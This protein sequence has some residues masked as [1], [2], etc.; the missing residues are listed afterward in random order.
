[1]MQVKDTHKSTM[2]EIRMACLSLVGAEKDMQLAPSKDR[3]LAPS[4]DRFALQTS[5][6]RFALQTTVFF[7]G[8]FCKRDLCF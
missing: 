3:Q 6:D 1:M 5:K 7:I 8:F 4:K 2:Q